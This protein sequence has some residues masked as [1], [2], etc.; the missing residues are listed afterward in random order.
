MAGLMKDDD[1]VISDINITPFVDVVLV[2]LII[3]MVTSTYIV[4]AAI[5]VELPKAASGGQSVNTTINLVLTKQGQLLL[6]GEEKGSREEVSQFIK[7]EATKDPKIQ[8]VIAADKGVP[9]GEV[10]KVIDLVKL[11]GVTS[12][13]LNIEREAPSN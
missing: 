13:A 5:E 9:Y 1:D 10:M 8:A 2:L 12:F 6:N 7:A 4:R 3:F 11:N